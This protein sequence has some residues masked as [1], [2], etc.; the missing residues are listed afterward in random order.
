MQAGLRGALYYF[1]VKTQA[2]VLNQKSGGT[3]LLSPWDRVGGCILPRD[4]GQQ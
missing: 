2:T 1:L 4:F 3:N